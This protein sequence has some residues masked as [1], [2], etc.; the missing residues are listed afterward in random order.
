MKK[1]LMLLCLVSVSA[2]AGGRYVYIGIRD[3]MS[4]ANK[5]KCLRKVEQIIGDNVDVWSITN[6][7]S[8]IGVWHSLPEWY[9]TAH[10]N[11]TLHI[12]CVDY[13]KPNSPSPPL[14]VT[15]AQFESWTMSN[16]G[17]QSNY[18]D[19]IRGDSEA[20]LTNKLTKIVP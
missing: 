7:A 4:N 10:T 19:F 11:I 6:K 15:V 17:S 1:L 14:T 2:L 8:A 18:V 5:L 12:L 3:D 16:L 9:V 20:V 13:L